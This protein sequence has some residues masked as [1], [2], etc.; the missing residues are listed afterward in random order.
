M[1]SVSDLKELLLRMKPKLSAE[2]Y[3]FCTIAEER[4]RS[5]NV[6]PIC[7]FR[8][9]EGV[10]AIIERRSAEAGSIRYSIAWKMITLTVHSDLE[11]VGFLAAVT[12]R[13]AREGISVNVVSAVRH[14]HLFVPS[15]MAEKAMK[16]LRELALE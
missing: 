16:A 2:E 11:A 14:D 3:I 6:K 5:S 12:G 13:L 1:A 10:T 8:E 7:T 9:K 15:N 4:F